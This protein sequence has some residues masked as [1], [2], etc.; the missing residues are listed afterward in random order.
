MDKALETIISTI[1]AKPNNADDITDSTPTDCGSDDEDSH[2]DGH[3]EN[4]IEIDNKVKFL[5]EFISFSLP[6]SRHQVLVDIG[7]TLVLSVHHPNPSV[8]AS[9]IS[10]LGKTLKSRNKVSSFPLSRL[11]TVKERDVNSCFQIKDN[12]CTKMMPSN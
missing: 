1:C 6:K 2:E 5:H 11:L 10:H 4:S 9:A 3:D 7:S 12:L 8:R